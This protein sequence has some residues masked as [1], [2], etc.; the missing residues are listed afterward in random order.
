MPV[1]IRI[2]HYDFQVQQFMDY[3]S[4]I[5]NSGIYYLQ[6]PKNI[7]FIRTVELDIDLIN[8][9]S[10]YFFHKHIQGR[11]LRVQSICQPH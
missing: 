3:W 1:K 10:S 8:Q 9:Q 7:I 11:V 6:R 4:L 5:F 2:A